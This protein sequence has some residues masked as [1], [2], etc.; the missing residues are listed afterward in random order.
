MLDSGRR[1]IGGERFVA[2]N[3]VPG[4]P[5]LITSRADAEVTPRTDPVVA[6]PDLLVL[7]NGV[8]VGRWHRPGGGTIWNESSFAI[9]AALV[10][11]PTIALELAAPQPLLSPYPDY[12]S[13]GYWFSQ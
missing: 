2:H 9:P 8:P 1:I 3:L 5:L 7:A 6:L 12:I 10:T 4:R 13:F 11:G